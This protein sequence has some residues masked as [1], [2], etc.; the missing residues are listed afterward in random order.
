MLSTRQALDRTRADET[1]LI[2]WAIAD[3]GF[4]LCVKSPSIAVSEKI[5]L[6]EIYAQR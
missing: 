4:V 1:Q 6:I 2:E 3:M 5:R